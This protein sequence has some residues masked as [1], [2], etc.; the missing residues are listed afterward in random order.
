MFQARIATVVL[1]VSAACFGLVPLFGRVLLESGLSPEAVALYRFGL[2]LPLAL[3]FL[4]RRRDAW[5]PVIA[6]AAAGLAGGVGWTAYLGAI[7]DVSVAAAGV[8]YLSYPV[9]V[10]VFSRL[11]TGRCIAPRAWVGALLVLAG[12][13]A[14]NGLGGV[15]LNA[16]LSIVP[17][18]VGFA[19]VVVAM[20]VIGHDLTTLERWSAIAV[21]HVIGLL[22]ATLMSDAGAMLP[23]PSQWAWVAGIAVVTATVPQLAY[24]WAARRVTPI[25]AATAGAAELPAMLA[26]G[27]IGF[28]ETVSAAE[29]L[30]ALL[31]VAALVV[32]PPALTGGSRRQDGF[33]ATRSPRAN[34]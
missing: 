10:L 3:A 23:S 30:G 14:V 32:S 5:K 19:L 13:I 25:R 26:V 28:G 11:I 31:M 6:L 20:A 12:A 15:D 24:T 34:G 29:G 2:A 18:P 9:F 7:D 8:V 21:G 1:V 27:W 16:V 4:P 17:A 22:P 33:A